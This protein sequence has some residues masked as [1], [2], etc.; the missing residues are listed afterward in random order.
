MRASASSAAFFEGPQPL[1][2]Q[3]SF[4]KTRAS[5]SRAWSSPLMWMTS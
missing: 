3:E 2:R 1:P 4:R 5:Y